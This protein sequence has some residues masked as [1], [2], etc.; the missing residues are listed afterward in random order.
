MDKY[1]ERTYYSYSWHQSHDQATVLLMVPYDT[2]VEDVVVV[3]ERNYLIVGVQGQPP[4]VKGRLYGNV[5]TTTSVWQLE[6]RTSHLSGRERKTSTVST[7]STQSSY[8]FVSDPEISSSFAASLESGQVSEAEDI[9]P[10]PVL[11]SP[12]L[13]SAD[14][15]ALPSLPR[16]KTH[17]NAGAS[18]S[19][20]PNHALRSMT[21]SFSSLESS[22]FPHSGRL[23]TLHLEK[24]QS[25]IWPSLIVGPVP[26]YLSPLVTDSV[27][28]NASHELEHQYNM[29]PTSLVLIALEL[30]D[31][32]KDKEE[33]FECFLRAWHQAHVP[34]A[35]MRLASHYLPPGST[36]NVDD[37]P[38]DP[39]PRGTTMYYLQCIGG[40]RG[41][42]QLYLEAGLLHLEGAASTLLSASYSSL[43]SIRMPLH[44][45]VGEGGTQAWKRDREA[46]ARYFERA[47]ALEPGL[48]IPSLPLTSP[49]DVEELEMPTMELG[50][51]APGSA[52]S[53]ASRNTDPDT[54]IVRR[55]RKKEEITLF[56]NK[57]AEDELDNT[58]YL[59]IPGLV[60]AGTAL[61]VV[62]IV[63]ALSLSTWSRR[64]QGS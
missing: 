17:S 48:E 53:G 51:S 29:D 32:R 23:L 26:D 54:P 11:S 41:L 27:I 40:R 19:T 52:C 15:R 36:Y 3:I 59:Y 2:Q 45:Q 57:V 61:L 25:I 49:H 37:T 13:S 6:P 14:E 64:N 50:A 42:A 30:F 47:S 5:G 56:D 4:I 31:I 34:S 38:A 20:S 16:R 22:Q 33:A 55:R 63:G 44:A 62:G 24:D 10:S 7:A 28:F 43:S 8:A 60:G 9:A 35:T 58:W 39:A 46:A 18:R 1:N 12:S 21:S